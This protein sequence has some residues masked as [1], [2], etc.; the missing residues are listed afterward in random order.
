M[1]PL[2]SVIVPIYN[3]EKFIDICV[4]SLLRQTINDI[5]IILVD[6]GSTDSSLQVCRKWEK[7][8]SRVILIHQENA[9]VSAARNN[10]VNVANGKYIGFCDVDDWIDDD[11]Y[12]ILYNNIIKTDS[13]ISIISLLVHKDNKE[14][15]VYGT[16][17]MYIWDDSNEPL[18][19]LF[20]ESVFCYAPYAQLIKAEYCKQYSFVVGR[21][22]NEDKFFAFNILKDADRICCQDICKYHYIV[23]ENS[24]STSEFGLKFFDCIFFAEKMLEIV[25]EEKPELIPDAMMNLHNTRVMVL[26]YMCKSKN[27]YKIYRKEY[28]ELCSLIKQHRIQHKI[29]GTDKLRTIELELL[30]KYPQIYYLIWKFINYIRRRK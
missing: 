5:E 17:A 14:I 9:G 28:L 30:L 13:M 24:A 29:G 2:I 15:P 11:M 4:G 6:D 18:K 21:K 16:N 10:G 26:K 8:D 19:Y 20:A 23:H 12:E 3:G 1:N 22:L 7:L 25:S 27:G